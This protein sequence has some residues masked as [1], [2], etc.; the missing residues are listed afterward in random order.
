MTYLNDLQCILLSNAARRDD[1]CLWPLPDSVSNPA[2]IKK[3]VS[4]LL[5][6]GLI[7]ERE[8]KSADISYRSADG[9]HY[10]VHITEAG[11]QAI[12][13]EPPAATMLLPPAPVSERLTKTALLKTLL[14]REQGA[15]M[16]ELTEATGWLPHT[17]RASLTGLRKKGALIERSSRDGRGC[18]HIRIAA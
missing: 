10:S 16:S 15:V 2:A 5:R 7:G 11:M 8:A 1:G 12:S 13:V 14:E 9:R 6:K 3:A 18:W 17:V 4:A